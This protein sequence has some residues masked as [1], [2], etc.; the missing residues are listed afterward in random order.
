MNHPSISAI[1]T[2]YNEERT[3]A[4]AIDS[5]EKALRSYTKD[6]EIIV[7]NDCSHDHT[8]IIINKKAKTN[9]RIIPIH[10]SKNSNIGYNLRIGVH[11]ANKEYIFAL[12]AADN[13]P[14]II[15]YQNLLSA[16]GTNDIVI[17]YQ[18]NYGNRVWL[19]RFLSRGFTLI[20]NILFG[21]RIRYY[22]G[23][24]IVKKE[25]WQTIPMTTNGFAYMA[26]VVA[27]LLKRGLTYTEIPI[28][29]TPELK[30]VNFWALRRNIFNVSKTIVSLFWRLNLKRQWYV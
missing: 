26:E 14:D 21:L 27:T 2:A 18:V 23:P 11:Q 29:L 6:Y 28:V 20:M 12:L 22:N 10:N 5:T 9:H 16:I 24:I 4:A 13:Y 17:G 1:I 3:V 25:I 30:G 8:G 7:V 19:R 15:Y